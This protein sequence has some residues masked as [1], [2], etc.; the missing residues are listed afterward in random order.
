MSKAST[1]PLAGHK[2]HCNKVIWATFTGET[3]ATC[4]CGWAER[5]AFRMLVMRGPRV[6]SEAAP[7]RSI[8]TS[9]HKVWTGKSRP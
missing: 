5:Q 7:D 8:Q 9:M 3:N 6:A 4:N 1:Y 2:G